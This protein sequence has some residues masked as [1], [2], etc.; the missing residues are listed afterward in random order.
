VELSEVRIG[1]EY[2]EEV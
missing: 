2:V 1:L